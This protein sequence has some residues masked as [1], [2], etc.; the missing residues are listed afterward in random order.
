MLLTVQ[1]SYDVSFKDQFIQK[2]DLIIFSVK[3]HSFVTSILYYHFLRHKTFMGRC[4]ISFILDMTTF[5]YISYSN[6]NV[7]LSGAFHFICQNLFHNCIIAQG[8]NI[9]NMQRNTAH[10]LVLSDNYQSYVYTCHC[11]NYLCSILK[12][13][14]Y[15]S[16]QFK[17]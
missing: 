3:Q 10:T 15:D 16:L 9:S 13:I 6:K 2:H 5:K 8:M 17:P 4:Y 7:S 12:I 1:Y 11:Y 14:S